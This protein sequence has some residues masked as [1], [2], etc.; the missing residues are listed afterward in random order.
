MFKSAWS[1]VNEFII[2]QGAAKARAI[3]IDVA[4][5]EA[6]GELPATAPDTAIMLEY[7]ET[8]KDYYV[9]QVARY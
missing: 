3:G 1:I 8:V 7:A 4:Y 2:Q 5:V 9:S 6:Q